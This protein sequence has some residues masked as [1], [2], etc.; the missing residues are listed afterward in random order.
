M[1]RLDSFITRMQAQRDCLNFLKPAIEAV[2]V[3]VTENAKNE[4]LA[5]DAY[6]FDL[7]ESLQKLSEDVV[8]YAEKR[9]SEKQYDE[10]EASLEDADAR[11][12]RRRPAVAIPG[13]PIREGPS[14]AIPDIG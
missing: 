14:L 6:G 2:K 13:I 10:A 7:Y 1:S 3:Y 11:G 4:K 8:A 12:R 5:R 9:I